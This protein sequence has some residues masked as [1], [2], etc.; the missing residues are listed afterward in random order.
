MGVIVDRV[1]GKILGRDGVFKEEEYRELRKRYLPQLQE[2]WN[3]M[4]QE[5]QKKQEVEE[6]AE[7]REKREDLERERNR[8]KERL[9]QIEAELEILNEEMEK[10]IGYNKLMCFR[11]KRNLTDEKQ[12]IEERLKEIEGKI[13]QP[14]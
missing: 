7:N 5:Q 3:R 2:E 12:R 8:L 13:K 11:E 9:S 1:L 4:L 10:E 14:F 6:T